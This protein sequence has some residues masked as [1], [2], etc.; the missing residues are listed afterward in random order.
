M[1]RKKPVIWNPSLII[2]LSTFF[3]EFKKKT[4]NLN[5]LSWYLFPTE[6]ETALPEFGEI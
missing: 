5:N 3:D 1:F 2:F 4:G 6:L